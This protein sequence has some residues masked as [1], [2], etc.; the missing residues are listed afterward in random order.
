M[1]SYCVI[2]PML[3]DARQRK[4]C[5]HNNNGIVDEPHE[6]YKE[7][8]IFNIWTEQEK[9][10]FKEKYLQH[11]KNFGYIASCLDRKVSQLEWVNLR[12]CVHNAHTPNNSLEI[13]PVCPQAHC[14][15]WAVRTHN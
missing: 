8:Q 10:I 13:I 15:K 14:H 7:R 2:P 9:E 4:L 3:L 5:F 6:D 1:R 12:P 11:P